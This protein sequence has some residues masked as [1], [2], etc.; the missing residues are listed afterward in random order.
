MAAPVIILRFRDTTPGTDTAHL[1]LLDRQGA[2]LWGWWRKEHEVASAVDVPEGP[3]EVLLAD[4]STRRMFRAASE[5]FS[6]R[7]AEID[8]L[9]VPH[10]TAPIPTK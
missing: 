5:R 2:V 9:E 7:G 1:E 8:P 6:A 10:T 3:L 4:R